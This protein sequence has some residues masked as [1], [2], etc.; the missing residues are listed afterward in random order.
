MRQDD[1][2][3]LPTELVLTF[4]RCQNYPRD[5]AAILLLA[6]GLR[7]ASDVT[8]IAM[9]LI[10]DRC[11]ETSQYCPTDAELLAAGR[12]I[13]EEIK[14]KREAARDLDAELRKQYG[15]PKPWKPEIDP[16]SLTAEQERTKIMKRVAKRL[17]IKDWNKDRHT[18]PEIYATMK[19][20]GYEIPPAARS[21]YGL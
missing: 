2:V 3:K 7:K 10:V 12:L 19:D 15:P 17:G 9:E 16:A 6:Q 1:E 4:A 11:A 13:T 14:R 5:Q 21:W 8:G 20:L 18:W